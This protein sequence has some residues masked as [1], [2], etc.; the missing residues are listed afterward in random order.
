MGKIAE[1]L[2]QDSVKKFAEGARE[3]N[4]GVAI[5]TGTNKQN[6]RTFLIFAAAGTTNF[7]I[8]EML[9]KELAGDDE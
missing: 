9:V 8:V 4:A 5:A 3:M 6:D 7:E 1:V 2:A